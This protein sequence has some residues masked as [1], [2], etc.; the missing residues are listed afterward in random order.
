MTTA[1]ALPEN[2]PGLPAAA[3]PMIELVPATIAAG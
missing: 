3:L 1:D 2:R